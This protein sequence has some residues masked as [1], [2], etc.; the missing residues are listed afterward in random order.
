LGEVLRFHVADELF[1][2]YRIDPDK[3]RAI[4]RIGGPSYVRVTDR[5]DMARPEVKRG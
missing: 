5:F 2:R 3:L 1:D 4:G